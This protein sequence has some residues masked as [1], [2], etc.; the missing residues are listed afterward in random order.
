MAGKPSIP[1]GVH[2][3]IR[4]LHSRG[5]TQSAIAEAV[6]CSRYTVCKA[7]NPDFAEQERQRHR[8]MGRDRY[9]AR[10]DDPDYISYQS[11]WN[12]TPE[13]LRKV[14]EGMRRL[15]KSRQA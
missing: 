10:K 5:M 11:A 12:T 1:A 13:R 4:Q 14:R 7:I 3:R 2:R 8:R 6:G 15:R 9:V